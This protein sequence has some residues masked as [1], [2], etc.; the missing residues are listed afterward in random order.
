[1]RAFRKRMKETSIKKAASPTR[2]V[3]KNNR[4]MDGGSSLNQ[5]MKLRRLFIESVLIYRRLLSELRSWLIQT[6]PSYFFA[7]VY[8]WLYRMAFGFTG[9][10]AKVLGGA[11]R[12][13]GSYS[14]VQ[15]VDFVPLV[16]DI[17]ITICFNR[18]SRRRLLALDFLAAIFP[19]LSIHI[20]TSRCQESI[21]KIFHHL[22]MGNI[23]FQD[24]KAWRIITKVLPQYFSRKS[25]DRLFLN[26]S[27]FL[28]AGM[29]QKDVDV[30]QNS[31]SQFHHL[32]RSAQDRQ[33]LIKD[34]GHIL[35]CLPSNKKEHLKTDRPHASECLKVVDFHHT[36][37]NHYD[38][39]FE[40]GVRA[41]AVDFHPWRYNDQQT[42]WVI[43]NDAPIDVLQ[44]LT[45]ELEKVP[46]PLSPFYKSYP[47]PII[48]CEKHLQNSY[49]PKFAFLPRYILREDQP[50]KVEAPM[51]CRKTMFA[52]VVYDSQLLLTDVWKMTRDR[53]ARGRINDLVDGLI[54]GLILL[55]KH[56][57]L[58]G[59]IEIIQRKFKESY[60]AHPLW[61]LQKEIR[62]SLPNIQR[63]QEALIPVLEELEKLARLIDNE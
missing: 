33:G 20:Q 55:L 32:R 24:W 25:S 18:I 29:L 37:K 40:R 13:S 10:I 46:N 17:D 16:S 30:I 21:S 58:Y 36:D 5:P 2:Q 8:N 59:D 19:F 6:S 31:R 47:A 23:Y 22:G 63:V 57:V 42:L 7:T 61:D 12:V 43:D 44:S 49:L 41:V 62:A 48:L 4:F 54:P 56:G 9:L 11:I 60:P 35:R 28:D 27:T 38:R 3:E 14:K 34:W 26:T 15:S 45:E 1:M 50:V 51:V 53:F 52:E 39:L